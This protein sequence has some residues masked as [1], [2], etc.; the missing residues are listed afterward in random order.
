M[1]TSRRPIFQ[2]RHNSSKRF[3]FLFFANNIPHSACCL[4]RILL[5]CFQVELMCDLIY[6][7]ISNQGNNG[8]SSVH[9]SCQSKPIVGYTRIWYT[10]P[11]TAFAKKYSR[12]SFA[13]TPRPHPPLILLLTSL[14]AVQSERLKQASVWHILQVL[15]Q[16]IWLLRIIRCLPSV[17]RPI[18]SV[19]I[20]C[21]FSGKRVHD[22]CSK[23]FKQFFLYYL[24]N[25][26]STEWH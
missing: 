17:F 18:T 4:L 26:C 5:L 22:A 2:C 25:S 21:R 1:V 20:I 14:C 16:V 19:N 7:L 24:Q 6:N 12:R 15:K 11:N 23:C 9:K 8:P 10:L 3:F 13:L